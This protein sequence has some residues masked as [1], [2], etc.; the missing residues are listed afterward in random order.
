MN[1]T[2]KTI[3]VTGGGS[4]IGFEIARLFS[5]KGNRVIITG[6][7]EQRLKEA[8]AQLDN[9]DYVAADITREQ[10]LDNLVAFVTLSYKG[11]DVLINNA[12]TTNIY[13]LG[14]A[15]A[16]EKAKN[17]IETNYLSVISLT[18]R[19][20]PILERQPESAIVNMNAIIGL[21]PSVHMPTH[22]ASKSA[23]R[24]YTQVLRYT[25]EGAGSKVKIFEV[26][27]PLVNTEFSRPIAKGTGIPPE[28]V[29]QA[30][31]EGLK[32]NTLEIRIGR[33]EQFYQAFFKGTEGALAALNALRK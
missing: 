14:A 19:F 12:A 21:T 9:V 18:E 16:Y 22:S 33:T 8:A 28:E 24:A 15:G 17:E 6:R 3:L 7:H 11:L 25:L 30:L 2:D 23:L 5:K 26:I 4:G 32:S 1:I 13:S 20:L 27:P 31:L 10:D 29:A